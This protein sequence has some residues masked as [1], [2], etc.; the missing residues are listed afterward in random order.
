MLQKKR[1]PKGGRMRPTPLRAATEGRRGAS[2]RMCSALLSP[3]VEEVRAP[4]D[5]GCAA[6]RAPPV[7]RFGSEAWFRSSELGADAQGH[8]DIAQYCSTMPN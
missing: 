3:C 6:G 5:T 7:V 2:R 1:R 8:G 4:P